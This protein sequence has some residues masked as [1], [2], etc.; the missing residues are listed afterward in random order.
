MTTFTCPM[1]PAL[2]GAPLEATIVTIGPGFVG[3]LAGLFAVVVVSLIVLRLRAR[4]RSRPAP[5][6]RE[7]AR[8]AA[9]P[10]MMP[11]HDSGNGGPR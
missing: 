5:S 1:P 7:A 6:R 10:Y 2:G 4:R 8:I 3:V 9:V 11:A